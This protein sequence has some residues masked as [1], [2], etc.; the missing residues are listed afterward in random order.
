MKRILSIAVALTL[1]ATSLCACKLTVKTDDNEGGNMA[2]MANPWTDI[3]EEEAYQLCANGFSAPEGAT[4]VRWSK[5]LPDNDPAKEYQ[6]LV[7]MKFDLD[8]VEYCARQQSVGDDSSVDISGMYFDW[9]KSEDVTLAGWAGG[10][11][12]G[13]VSTYDGDDESARLCRWYDV[14]TGDAYSLSAAGQD[15]SKVDIKKVAEAI[16]DP[17]KQ[18]GANAP[19][20]PETCPEEATDDFLAKAAEECAPNIDISGCDTFTQIVDKKLSDGMGYAN[21][22]IGGEDVLLVSSGTYDNMDGNMASIDAAIFMYK[23]SV[24]YEVGKVTCGGTAYPLTVKDGALYT[25]SNHWVVKWTIDG[26]K[27]AI[28]KKGV[29]V[30]DGNGNE[31]YYF[32]SSEGDDVVLADTVKTKQQ[33][34]DLFDEMM[35]ANV[36]DFST[37]GGAVSALPAYEYPGPELFYSVLYQY[38]ID[39]FAGNYPDAAVCIPCPVIIAEDESDK[40]DIKVWG[41]FQIYKYDLNGEE[42]DCTSGGSYPGCIHLKSVD[43]SRG[44]VVEKMDLVGDGSDYEP[45]AKRI[46]GKHYDE[47]VKSSADTEG[48]EKLRAQIIADYVGENS[49]NITAYKD[50]GWDPVKLPPES[51]DSLYSQLN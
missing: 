9:Q 50:Y 22:T 18:V 2:G 19:G 35:N 33:V 25:G 47:L 37:V 11:M 38:L 48:R 4:N 32:E 28:T 24:P 15:M 43:D 49:L 3:T 29:I 36:V 27:L 13:T 17:K 45:T 7:Q 44:Y 23:D 16:Y 6:T 12:K 42:L 8:G 40:S 30:F 34:D 20:I 51:T 46:F 41:D 1:L 5:M 10:N 14:E 31:S 26:D 39:E 21:E